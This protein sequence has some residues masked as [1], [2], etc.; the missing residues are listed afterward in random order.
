MSKSR[1]LEKHK[2]DAYKAMTI[3]QRS[4]GQGGL[5]ASI[6][7]PSRCCAGLKGEEGPEAE[8]RPMEASPAEKQASAE[9]KPHVLGAL[10]RGWG[11]YF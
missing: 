9:R 1:T 6:M 3:M 8:A 10:A 5:L 4:G 2:P 11:R 7:R